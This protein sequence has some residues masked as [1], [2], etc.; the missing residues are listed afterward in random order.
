MCYCESWGKFVIEFSHSVM[1]E[2]FVSWDIGIE[3]SLMIIG[4]FMDLGYIYYWLTYRLLWVRSLSPTHPPLRHLTILAR[5]SSSS[6]LLSHDVRLCSPIHQRLGPDCLPGD[7]IIASCT[8]VDRDLWFES[9]GM[10]DQRMMHGYR[11]DGG[12]VKCAFSNGTAKMPITAWS[13]FP[14]MK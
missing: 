10:A 1:N 2:T 8:T 11:F 3:Y 14:R 12:F 6:L 7:V 9:F 13:F 4:L 5:L